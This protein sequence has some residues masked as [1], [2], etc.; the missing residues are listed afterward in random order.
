MCTS[1]IYEYA[2]PSMICAERVWLILP[3]RIIRCRLSCFGGRGGNRTH[4]GQCDCPPHGFEGRDRHQT[5]SA[6]AT[7]IANRPDGIRFRYNDS[8]SFARC[9]QSRFQP[10]GLHSYRVQ[11]LFDPG[12][13]WS[14]LLSFVIS[15]FFRHSCFLSSSLLSFVFPAFFRHP[16]FLSSSLLSF[17][18]PAQAGTQTISAKGF[19][20]VQDSWSQRG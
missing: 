19:S 7:M 12:L 16:C 18:I 20:V 13:A 1:T 3:G 4:R 5:A 15:A 14:F 8:K 9:K 17:V 2:G 11:N 10:R 6:S